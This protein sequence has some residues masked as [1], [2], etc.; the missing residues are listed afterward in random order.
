MDTLYK[1]ATDNYGKIYFLDGM[2]R[3]LAETDKIEDDEQ[4][5]IWVAT[6]AEDCILSSTTMIN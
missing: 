6:V 3:V 1:I 2:N 5:A 4:L